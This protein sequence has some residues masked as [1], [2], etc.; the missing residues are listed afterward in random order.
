ARSALEAAYKSRAIIFGEHSPRATEAR[1]LL[2][3]AKKEYDAFVQA[4]DKKKPKKP[5]A[6]AAA[7]QPPAQ[8]TSTSS[9]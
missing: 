1:R 3:S 4:T 2:D 7:P 9:A 5:E 8:A 6:P